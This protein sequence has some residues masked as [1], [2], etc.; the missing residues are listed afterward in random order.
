[1]FSLSLVP[2]AKIQC[3][4]GFPSEKSAPWWV[5]TSVRIISWP[6]F[7][8]ATSS[9]KVSAI[10]GLG[11]ASKST[12]EAKSLCNPLRIYTTLTRRRCLRLEWTNMGSIDSYHQIV[13][14]LFSNFQ[15][16][17]HENQKSLGLMKKSKDPWT[18]I[19]H[20]SLLTHFFSSSPLLETH[21][22]SGLELWSTNPLELLGSLGRIGNIYRNDKN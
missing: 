21:R 10:N 13:L 11:F 1:M 12:G 9:C 20:P 16:I 18:F 15:T 4:H 8:G 14:Q 5:K 17:F 22:R 19:L 2:S 7:C 6:A 3:S